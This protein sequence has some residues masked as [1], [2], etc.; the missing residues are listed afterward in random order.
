MGISPEICNTEIAGDMHSEDRHRVDA[1]MPREK[2]YQ[3][4]FYP[5]IHTAGM[6]QPFLYLK[7]FIRPPLLLPSPI[8][9]VSQQLF[10][11]E[12]DV[13]SRLILPGVDER[14]FHYRY[15]GRAESIRFMVLGR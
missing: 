13:H 3:I 4:G 9:I 15:I 10:D 12:P 5:F 7:K 14:D 6:D 1:R 2:D 8:G 11:M